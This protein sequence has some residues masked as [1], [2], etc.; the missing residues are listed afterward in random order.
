MFGNF[1]LRQF[2]KSHA[3]NVPE[4][5]RGQILNLIDKN[6]EFF[7]KVATETQEK[8]KQGKNQQAAIMEVMRAHQKKLR[9]FL[10]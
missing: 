4:A 2:L 9:G 5:Q 10:K 7:K 1:F 6:P 3:K 8:V